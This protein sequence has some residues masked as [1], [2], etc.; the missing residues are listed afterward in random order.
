MFPSKAMDVMLSFL[1]TIYRCWCNWWFDVR[2]GPDHRAWQC[3]LYWWW[4]CPLS[5]FCK[6]Y[7]RSQL[8]YHHRRWTRVQRWTYVRMIMQ[9]NLFTRILWSLRVVTL[10]NISRASKLSYSFSYI[11]SLHVLVDHVPLITATSCISVPKGYLSDIIIC[12]Y[13]FSTFRHIQA[14]MLSVVTTEL[15]Q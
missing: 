15:S 7:N 8:H 4:D 11:A 14:Y 3:R 10:H 5:V 1:S 9:W 13:H 6:R 12:K 2:N